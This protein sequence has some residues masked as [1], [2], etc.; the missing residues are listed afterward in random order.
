[1]PLSP[2]KLGTGPDPYPE[3]LNDLKS[4]FGSLPEWNTLA[5]HCLSCNRMKPVDRWEMSRQQGKQTVISC[6]LPKLRCECG[7]K[8][9]SEW[10]MGRLPRY[11]RPGCTARGWDQGVRAAVSSSAAQFKGVSASRA[12][13]RRGLSKQSS[14]SSDDVT[15]RI[16]GTHG[17]VKT[18]PFLH[19][20]ASSSGAQR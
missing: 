6:L 8:G 1:M 2:P 19:K 10:R 20:R 9:N 18:I 12:S 4:T 3:V 13:R 16:Q 7:V 11:L 14:P 5:I 15:A 17:S